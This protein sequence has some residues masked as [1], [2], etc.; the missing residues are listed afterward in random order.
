M[1]ALDWNSPA[2]SCI[3]I[4][5]HLKAFGRRGSEGRELRKIP[6]E[7]IAD[8][9]KSGFIR[10]MVPKR[11]GGLEV[12]PQEFF[13]AQIEIAEHDMSTAWVAGIIAVHAFQLAL[14]DENAQQDV[15]GDDPDCCVSSS[16]NPVGGKTEVTD[17]GIMLSGHWGWS[18]GCDHCD[19]VLLGAIVA[20]EG[21]RT[22]LLPRSDYQI[23][24]TW[25]S[26]GLQATGS[27][28]IIID[29]PVFVPDYRTHKQMD[30]FNC[31]NQQP[32]PMYSMPWAQTFI[33]VVS[34]PAI[35]AARHALSL[36]I[37]NASTSSTDVTR[38][39][40][41]PD[42]LRRVV[43]TENLIDQAHTMMLRNFNAMMQRVMNGQEVSIEDRVRYRYQAA[44]VIGEM[45]RA[46][47]LLFDVAG[48][49]S[50]YLG[51][52]IQQIWHDIHIARAHVANSPVSFARNW[53]N[54]MLGGENQDFFI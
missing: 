17:G 18:S 31:L 30:G 52:E 43:E 4:Q 16:Y 46:V 26:M 33:R 45:I 5:P 50:V 23:E 42:V 11:W 3:D 21:Y 49:R 44:T 38:L 19:W 6:D 40:G 32:N 51:S 14:M 53:G 2:D 22:F 39:V 29:E 12:T 37:E 13:S 41:D 28:D 35:G 25:F 34:S 47:D 8:L 9:K 36:F 27:N 15:Y 20:G 54:M 7:S 48:G 1:H 10:S 24:D